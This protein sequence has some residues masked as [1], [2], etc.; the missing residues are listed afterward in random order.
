MKDIL[1]VVT[2]GF[3]IGAGFAVWAPQNPVVFGG[4]FFT[5]FTAASALI[6]YAYWRWNR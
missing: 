4:G 1:T 5:G 6:C 2:A 3:S